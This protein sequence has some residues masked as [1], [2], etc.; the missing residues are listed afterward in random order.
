MLF[1]VLI[2][3]G[4]AFWFVRYIGSHSDVYSEEPYVAN[5]PAAGEAAHIQSISTGW[6]SAEWAD[7]VFP[8]AT[9]KLD[10][11]KSSSGELRVLF[12][13]DVGIGESE[14]KSIG[15]SNTLKVTAG[16]FSNGKNEITITCTKGL[17]GMAD[18]LAY[19]SQTHH[20]WIIEVLEQPSGKSNFEA[21][22]Q[23]PIEPVIIK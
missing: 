16:K 12:K 7:T 22:A 15:D 5:T 8:T 23:A 20:R 13:K 3:A 18:F 1:S 9:I 4:L 10:S 19:Q 6:K 17:D 11:S 21:F 14:S 2:L